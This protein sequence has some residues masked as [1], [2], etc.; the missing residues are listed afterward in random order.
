LRVRLLLPE[1]AAAVL[2]VGATKVATKAPVS[3][4]LRVGRRVRALRLKKN[5]SQQKFA[6]RLGVTFQQ[7]QKYENGTDHIG[8]ARLQIIADILE[9]PV[10]DFFAS[11]GQRASPPRGFFKML[12]KA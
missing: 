2:I 12:N 9:I 10:Y 11:A 5:L 7:V 4:D 3:L 6:D 1:D 8:V